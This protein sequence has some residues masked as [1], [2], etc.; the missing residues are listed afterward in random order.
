ME[1]TTRICIIGATGSIGRS[2]LDVVREHPDRFDVVGLAA[3]RDYRQLTQ[4]VGEFSPASVALAEKDAAR[5]LADEC[6]GVD[7]RAGDDGVA[8]LAALDAADV[9][10]IAIVG[11]AGLAPA[12]A[13]A[14]AGKRVALA[15]KETLV[16][17]GHLL[18]AEAADHG[19]EIIPVDSEHC[20]VFQCLHSAGSRANE[21]VERI[22]LTASG[23]PFRAASP[24]ELARVT[25]AQALAHPTWNMGAKISIDSATLM[26]KGLEVIEAHW[27]FHMP[28]DRIDVVIHPQSIVH[29]LVEFCDGAA[30]A[31]LS[32][33]DMRLPI[34]YAF[35]YPERH[36]LT[37]PRLN[38]ADIRHLTFEEPDMQAFPCLRLAYEALEAGGTATTVLNAANEVAVSRFLD[39]HISF[40]DIPRHIDAALAA[41]TVVP[42]PTLEEIRAADT[43][44]RE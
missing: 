1:E 18:L 12:L 35:T 40:L 42:D 36:H 21:C 6:P 4:L 26:N 11:M 23:G 13:A 25:P 24:D 17:A 7:V 22:I 43:W 33:P 2:A 34:M 10:L 30:L 20:A 41:H 19:A 8:S 29:S 3:R 5:A 16:A 38:L 9:V 44:A 28:P 14:R 39:G 37:L 32:A 27:L 15:T 31:Q